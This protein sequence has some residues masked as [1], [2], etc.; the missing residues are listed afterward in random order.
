MHSAKN[1]KGT[2]IFVQSDFSKATLPKRK[3]LWETAKEDKAIGEEAYLIHDKLKLDGTLHAWD[4]SKNCRV[5]IN[6]PRSRKTD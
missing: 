6:A 3:L 5:V 4:D 1:L 2:D